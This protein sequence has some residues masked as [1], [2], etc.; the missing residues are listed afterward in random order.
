MNLNL[1]R[2][3]IP[4]F[5]IT[6]IIS[7]ELSFYNKTHIS[8]QINSELTSKIYLDTDKYIF[9]Q[10]DLSNITNNFPILIKVSLVDSPSSSSLSSP[11]IF[12]CLSSEN[13]FPN[14]EKYDFQSSNEKENFIILD[15]DIFNRNIN[16]R[17]VYFSIYCEAE[18]EYRL[19][20]RHESTI[21]IYSNIEYYLYVRPTTAEEVIYKYRN[22]KNEFDIFVYPPSNDI[23]FNIE[24][25]KTEENLHKS[26]QIKIKDFYG[27]KERSIKKE[28][29][30]FCEECD[31][32][33]RITFK[34][35]TEYGFKDNEIIRQY[36]VMSIY[37]KVDVQILNEYK[38]LFDILSLNEEYCYKYIIKNTYT[39]G[40]EVNKKE[41]IILSIGIMEGNVDLF[42]KKEDNQ[43][44]F[45]NKTNLFINSVYKIKYEDYNL[46]SNDILHI[47]LK[48]NKDSL[49][50]IKAVLQRNLYRYSNYNF[51]INNNFVIGWLDEGSSTTYR[52]T[53]YGKSIKGMTVRLKQV[54]SST[55]VIVKYCPVMN[56]CLLFNENIENDEKGVMS[57]NVNNNELY[58][59]VHIDPSKYSCNDRSGDVCGFIVIVQCLGNNECEY[60]IGYFLDENY[61]E[62]KENVI[63]TSSIIRR[64]Y[65]Q[66]KIRIYDNNILSI[67]IIFDNIIGDSRLFLKKGVKAS[68]EEIKDY[69]NYN[70]RK[71][72]EI[73]QD[74]NNSL[75]GEYF[76]YIH[77]EDGLTN[78]E[79]YSIYYYTINRN[80]KNT[81]TMTM[82]NQEI[83]S[84]SRVLL[85][86]KG[87]FIY[88][89]I[90]D[91]ENEYSS[92]FRIYSY[93]VDYSETSK[94]EIKVLLSSIKGEFVIYLY[95]PNSSI[96]YNS[97]SHSF[98]GYHSSTLSSLSDTH[99][100]FSMDDLKYIRSGEY[101]IVV[102]LY[103]SPLFHE[104]SYYIAASNE[105]DGFLVNVNIPI[106]LTL[107]EKTYK[108]D[109]FFYKIPNYNTTL[110][111]NENQL[112]ISYQLKF[113]IY[114]GNI[115]V[116][117]FFEKHRKSK[118]GALYKSTQC[119][120]LCNIQINITDFFK[121][122][123]KIGYVRLSLEDDTSSEKE[124]YNTAS[125][126][127]F[128][129]LEMMSRRS[130][131]QFELLIQGIVKSDSILSSDHD[132]IKYYKSYIP[133]LNNQT[134]TV[135]VMFKN[136]EGR[137]YS[138]LV[139]FD[140]EDDVEN[141]FLSKKNMTFSEG[142]VNFSKDKY[143]N[144]L[145]LTDDDVKISCE[146]RKNCI[147]LI[148]I[149]LMNEYEKIEYDIS[150][151][152]SNIFEIK[153]NKEVI[154]SLSQGE[155]KFYYIEINEALSKIEN[156]L[157]SLTSLDGDA[158]LYIYYSKE[159]SKIP[160]IDEFQFKSVTFDKEKV[161][162]NSN[163]DYFTKNNITSISGIYTIAVFSFF[164]S[165]FS[166]TI[167]TNNN[168][169]LRVSEVYPQSCK[170]SSYEECVFIYNI[171]INYNR[172]K[173]IHEVLFYFS[174][175]YGAVDASAI[176][177]SDF[178]KDVF[179]SFINDNQFDIKN[180]LKIYKND[181]YKDLIYIKIDNYKGDSTYNLYFLLKVK[182]VYKCH[183]LIYSLS[184]NLLN[185]TY[186]INPS[187]D[188]I[189]YL[190]NDSEQDIQILFSPNTQHKN[191]GKYSLYIEILYGEVSLS[192]YEKDISKSAINHQK[193]LKLN[194]EKNRY[195]YINSNEMSDL[196]VCKAVNKEKG[197]ENSY[198]SMLNIGKV[199]LYRII[200][201][202][203]HLKLYYGI[204]NIIPIRLYKKDIN[205]KISIQTYLLL[206]KEYDYVDLSISCRE[207]KDCHIKVYGEYEKI[208]RQ[209]LKNGE[210]RL[211]S[212]V[213]DKNL[214]DD[215]EE[216]SI[217]KKI[218][219]KR[220]EN[221]DDYYI[222]ISH[223][224]IYKLL[225]EYENDLYNDN[226]L[227]NNYLIISLTPSIRSSN[228]HIHVSHIEQDTLVFST[229]SI[230]EK[231][232]HIFLFEK[233]D[234]KAN[235]KNGF[236]ISIS[237]CEVHSQRT[238][239]NQEFEEIEYMVIEKEELI[240]NKDIE[241]IL[242]DER[243]KEKKYNIL[244]K[245]NYV[246]VINYQSNSN[247]IYFVVYNSYQQPF[248]SHINRNITYC[249]YFTSNKEYSLRLFNREER[250]IYDI[251]RNSISFY[252][253]P[254]KTTSYF[255][256]YTENQSSIENLNSICV[257]TNLKKMKERLIK[258]IKIIPDRY[259]DKE[260]IYMYTIPFKSG[261][262]YIN[263]GAMM[264]NGEIILYDS[265]EIYIKSS[266][267]IT[268]LLIFIVLLVLSLIIFKV[269]I[270]FRRERKS[271]DRNNQEMDMKGEGESESKEM[272]QFKKR[273]N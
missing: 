211:K 127:Q 15:K 159:Y 105:D 27:G 203:K 239:S 189:V 122:F 206:G 18:C 123:T 115:K 146:Y 102:S 137:I 173:V 75:E 240:V 113:N 133:L 81:L 232:Y 55:K 62:L 220:I 160:S 194:V 93:Y 47:C 225:I 89:S 235:S 177:M 262:Y 196:Y 156:I 242:E 224:T 136:I 270:F 108:K 157:F 100:V 210:D 129:L 25:Y 205:N 79:N 221:N 192:C 182:C 172:G 149:E 273:E 77:S 33:F 249:L 261:T 99:V 96:T 152:S 110:S 251:N 144:I 126:L 185:N 119:N 212:V 170:G 71:K 167:S 227:N 257:I 5:L 200:S 72:Y 70:N 32:F 92:P 228:S 90:L 214:V 109:E 8:L 83:K 51:L 174:L 207:I 184:N 198:N 7:Q 179:D 103:E 217:I 253:F 73:N 204:E 57:S 36:V 165:T 142:K 85:N 247:H 19:S 35:N 244:K 38:P 176:V 56:L 188:N 43:V 128:I 34:F 271:K 147:L 263:I 197:N 10:L 2:Q 190:G 175:V 178:D 130:K 265:I 29:D 132:R 11:F 114:S 168:K 193:N 231:D 12:L 74:D 84:K 145:I 209:I 101:L 264:T 248:D 28:S 219:K 139:S 61:V 154:S 118:D 20:I 135:S 80:D 6:K 30:D 95:L 223:I 107:N 164:K 125:K 106:M 254:Y 9:Y 258:Y 49:F 87:L 218:L 124:I 186:V 52:L 216:T 255:L 63:I 236:I 117:I 50:M 112:S 42:I 222:D 215:F 17:M 153:L 141:E 76:L 238:M 31:Y 150:I 68:I 91:N 259:L 53:E 138:K 23:K 67:V 166:L 234:Q 45:F 121:N 246:Q 58:D 97:S 64:E 229:L 116:R 201:Y 98:F 40:L 269:F 131:S 241:M 181:I 272:S 155:Y 1:I 104:S 213:A 88:D 252:A 266:I 226:N 39:R 268:V 4:I 140:D 26:K 162:I 44:I 260:N 163:N 65:D 199:L 13:Q 46:T 250:I 14:E 183:S 202:E 151:Y 54:K 37:E 230:M 161:L 134:T 60:E 22:K 86:N 3:I 78:F 69:S 158:D 41:S 48:A 21:Q 59:Y 245:N 233:D 256:Y 82:S 208:E 169:I 237:T 16:S 24:A 180:N 148:G 143:E 94:K 187:Y 66:Y 243:K 111:N 191:Q 267:L 120:N 171:D 195:Y